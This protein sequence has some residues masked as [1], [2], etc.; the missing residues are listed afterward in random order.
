M[1]PRTAATCKHLSRAV[2][3]G[4]LAIAVAGCGGSGGGR[5]S[6]ASSPLDSIVPSA[7]AEI[8]E[9][10]PQPGDGTEL[11]APAP[12]PVEAIRQYLSA[13]I[14]GDG[15][16]S[17]GLLSASSR[18]SAGSTAD[19]VE[20]A[21]QRPSIVSYELD[22]SDNSETT[23]RDAVT[24]TGTVVLQ[25]R[26]DEV[27]GFVPERAD[28]DWRVVAED[29]GWRVDIVDS[30]LNPILPDDAGATAAAATWAAAR[31]DCRSDG[32]YAG[33]LLGSPVLG[34]QLCG[35]HGVL[36][37]GSPAPLGDTLS[38]E[39]VAAFGPDATT[40]ARTVPLSGAAQ[41]TVVTAPFGDHWVVVGVTG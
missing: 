15:A 29:G 30:T 39:V 27:S 26:L 33:S 35:V 19:W 10:R 25:P 36:V 38:T 5:S 9:F 8:P 7:P 41:L 17:F 3:I 16:R 13:E 1:N 14:A 6:S 34:D 32:E 40:W 31:Q 37:A 4:V 2:S 23:G 11:P 18:T 21:F 20:T 22:R 28:V 24:V 12:D